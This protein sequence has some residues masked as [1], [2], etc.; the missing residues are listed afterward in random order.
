M[1]WLDRLKDAGIPGWALAALAFVAVLA[2]PL[3]QAVAR[4]RV[5]GATAAQQEEITSQV[6]QVGQR[7]ERML[8]RLERRIA[9]VERDLK[10]C[11]EAHAECRRLYDQLAARCQACQ[12][13]SI[14]DA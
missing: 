3:T 12:A 5:A 8:D 13:G 7:Y 10:E 14:G 2:R 1:D 11:S 6:D 9:Q 4:W